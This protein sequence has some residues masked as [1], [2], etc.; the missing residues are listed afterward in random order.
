MKSPEH[1][2]IQNIQPIEYMIVCL[3]KDEFKGYLKGNIIKYISR[4]ERKNGDED[5]QKAAQFSKWLEEFTTTGS[6]T[7]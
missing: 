1:Y 7:L 2:S 3:S 4:A 6:I 5:Y